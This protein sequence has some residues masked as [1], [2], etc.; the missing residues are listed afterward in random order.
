MEDPLFR[1]IRRHANRRLGLDPDTP[2]PQRLSGLRE[3]LRLENEMLQR[4]HAKGDSGRRVA[5]ARTIV[6]DVLLESLFNLAVRRFENGHGKLGV[7]VSLL[8]LGGYGREELCPHSDIDIMF[9]FPRKTKARNLRTLQESLT[10]DILYPLWD[11][12]LKVGHSTRNVRE[13]LEE[14][15]KD[16]QTKNAL[17]EARLITGSRP[18]YEVFEQ[19]FKNYYQRENP[20]SYITSRLHDQETRRARYGGTVFLQEPDIKNGVGGLRDYQNIL[21]MAQIRLDV[22]QLDEL[23]RRN[24]LRKSEQ[25]ELEEAYD[26]LLRV[27]TELHL[28]SKR[29]TDLLN[30][31]R[32]PAVAYALGY[33]STNIFRR[34]ERF[35]RDY[36]RHAQNIYLI[37]RLLEQRLAIT[38]MP[39]PEPISFKAVLESRRLD[40]QKR[41]DGFVLRGNLMGYEHSGIFEEDP[42][43]LVR[44]FRYLQQYRAK[45]DLDLTVAVRDA[46]PLITNQLIHDEKA[47][48]TF[49]SLL[50]TVGEVYEPLS[51]MHELGVLGRFLPEFGELTCLVQHEFYHRYTADIHTLNTI[52]ELDA[53]FSGEND[54]RPKYLQAIR[55]TGT[56]ALLYLILLLHDIGKSRG[57]ENHTQTGVEVAEPIL[58]R[59]GVAA[60]LRGTILFIIRNHLEMARFWQKH[61]V[62]EPR[63][64]AAFAELV[65]DTQ[66]LRYLYVHTF[67]D[68]RGTAH[69]LWN[70]YKDIL[71]NR[72]YERTLEQLGEE[73]A[74]E[75]KREQRKAMILKEL[76][77]KTIPG[78]PREEVEAHFNLLPER[79]FLHNSPG[80]I[81]L[82]LKMV[83]ELLTN[84]SQ[85]ESVGSLVPII[86]WRDDTDQGLTVVNVVTW[87]RA[88]LFCKLAGAFTVAGLN[89]LSTKAISRSD[90]ITIDTFYVVEPGGGVVRST[91]ARETF[92]SSMKEA[93]LHNKDLM[94]DIEAQARKHAKPDYLRSR[95]RLQAPIPPRVDVYHEL[96]LR[97]TIIEVQAN[98]HIGLLYKLARAMFEHGYD[99]TFARISTERAVALD[100]FYIEQIDKEHATDGTSSLLTLRDDLNTILQESPAQAAI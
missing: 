17:L 12:G 92:E 63:V 31:D 86:D 30:L 47:N 24:Y 55:Q 14:A 2:A 67:C 33:R 42:A 36:Y 28:Q 90:H 22:A 27:R 10:D 38:G 61:D 74:F 84:I 20:Q 11:L 7:Q 62:D 96:S 51:L 94:A 70:S 35:M 26:F 77:E 48:R 56:P 53:I 34:V 23:T 78:I 75:E 50:Q 98:D 97:R 80:E 18:L 44:L 100:T 83:N 54:E 58:E 8:A 87:D 16:V 71:H 13:A 4:Y 82:H 41:F 60:E 89:I 81:E 25:K 91:E 69:G 66:K 52:R 37:S 72:L 43:R 45:L 85:A 49:R 5:K 40:K 88:G 99:I 3:Y 21:W 15:K 79:Y 57:I 93:L 64:S 29:A 46:L 73:G 1:R 19:A 9:L 95:T 59:L 76:V 39:G 32:Q 65:E 68:A 6:I